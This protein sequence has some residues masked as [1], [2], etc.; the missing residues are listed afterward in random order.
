MGLDHMVDKRS[1]KGPVAKVDLPKN[2]GQQT[3][4]K[5][6]REE[7]VDGVMLAPPCGPL[8]ELDK[9]HC[10]RSCVFAVVCNRCN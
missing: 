9:N 7:K 8:H 1:V 10:Q 3:V 2:A 4:L 5:W 6:I